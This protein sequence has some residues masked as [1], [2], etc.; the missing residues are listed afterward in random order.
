MRLVT[1]DGHEFYIRLECMVIK[2]RDDDLWQI[3]AAV[4]DITERKSAQTQRDTLITELQKALSEVKT[5]RGFLP[6]CAN[7]KDIRNDRGYWEKI[8]TYI[9]DRSD[10]EFSHSLCPKCAKELYPYMDI[11]DDNDQVIED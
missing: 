2:I 5:L 9:R 6:I 11:Y 10:A 4:S 1:I 7:C 8:E 3:R